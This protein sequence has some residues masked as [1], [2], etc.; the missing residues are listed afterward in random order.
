M[1]FRPA[2]EAIL[3]RL[4]DKSRRQ[5]LLFSATMP[6]DVRSI[7]DA[8][9]RPSYRF[10]DCVGA[11]EST[12]QHVAQRYV[13]STVGDQAAELVALLRAAIADGTADGTGYKV[14]VFF[15]TARLTQFYAELCNLLGFNVL[16]MHSRKS[17]SHRNRV[18]DL[19]RNGSNLI[20]FSSDVSARGM[21]YPDISAVM[22][23]GLPADRAQ[24]IHRLGRTAR[25]GKG[26][27]GVL[28]LCD[29]ERG[30]LDAVRDLPLR[31]GR[32]SDPATL[33]AVRP[34]I[35]AA[36]RRLSN[37]T[38][39]MA[40]Q[41]FL[42]YYNSNLRK[43]GWSKEQLVSVANGWATEVCMQPEPPALQAKTIG[44]MGLKGVAGL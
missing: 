12:H 40:Y 39:S 28:L 32:G 8:A 25:A 14:I 24:Y 10:V 29:F 42:G 27:E 16:E 36:M 23:V 7:A 17:Q 20:M 34:T 44:K 18:S 35:D 3:R 13:I 1:G 5:T 6:S 26:G 2:I 21:D 41:A 37:E 4:P 19:F 22:Q 15:T 30:F 43:V 31:P 38:C 33:T 11:E 9:L